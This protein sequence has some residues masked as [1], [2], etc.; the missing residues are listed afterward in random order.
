MLIYSGGTDGPGELYYNFSVSNDLTQI[1]T[2]ILDCDSH[3]ASLLDLFSSSNV[4]ICSTMDFLPFGNSDVVVLVSF[5]FASNSKQNAPF[6]CIV[7]GYSRAYWNGLRDRLRHVPWE[8][9]STH[10]APAAAT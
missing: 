2:W 5:D 10:N 9:I 3:S 6:Q 8:N 1:V 7:Y 4:S